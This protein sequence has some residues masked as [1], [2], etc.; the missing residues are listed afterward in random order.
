VIPFP[1][2]PL[3]LH[4][5]LNY[6]KVGDMPTRFKYAPVQPQ[7]FALTPAEILMATDAELN[8]Y[9]SVKRYAPY[10]KEIRWDSTRNNRLAELKQKV[11][12]RAPSGWDASEERPA[13]KRKGKKERQ[14]MRIPKAPEGNAQADATVEGSDGPLREKRKRVDGDDGEEGV[15]ASREVGKTGKKRRRHKKATAQ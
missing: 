4:I 1:L 8:E 14:K 10:R 6:S 3:I 12:E 9:L 11:A 15:E 5:S 2:H 7:S 13:K